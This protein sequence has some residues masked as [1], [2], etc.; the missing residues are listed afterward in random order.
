M[1]SRHLEIMVPLA[2]L[3]CPKLTAQGDEID[4]SRDVRPILA[5]HCFKCHG[6]DDKARKAKL[7]LDVR[8]TL[9]QRGLAFFQRGVAEGIGSYG[10]DKAWGFWWRKSHLGRWVL[11]HDKTRG[12]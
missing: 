2:I 3:F 4:F 11:R 9:F 12:Q 5:R 1:R 7:R 6:P 8:D 10:G